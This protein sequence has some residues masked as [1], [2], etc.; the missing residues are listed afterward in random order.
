MSQDYISALFDGLFFI[1]AG[2]L[3]LLSS[4]IESYAVFQQ[5]GFMT[6]L[7]DSLPGLG[8]SAGAILLGVILYR[9]SSKAK[10]P[11]VFDRY[12]G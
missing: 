11:L 10:Q 9:L 8:L 4:L 1:L 3:I 7:I 2:L 5:S 12:S 6:A